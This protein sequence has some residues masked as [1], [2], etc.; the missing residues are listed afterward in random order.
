[1]DATTIDARRSSIDK[2]PIPPPPFDRLPDEIIEQILQATDPNGFASL[3]LLN[4]KWRAASQRSHL[5][6]HHLAKCPSYSTSH[7]TLPSLDDDSLPRLRRLFARE[8]KR[9]LFQAYLRPNQTVIKLISNSISSSSCPGGEGMQFSASPKGHHI[10]AYNSAR[11]YVIDVR[12]SSVELKREFKILR[13]PVAACIND[14]ASLLAV[15]STEMQVDLYD[16][17]QSPPRRTQSMIL[18]NSPRTIALSPCGS[19]LA[20]AYEGGIEVS[21]LRPGALSTDRRAVKCDAVDALAFSYDGTQILGTTTLSAP[22]STVILTAPYYDPGSHMSEENLSALWTTSI[23]FPNTSRDCSHA[24]LLQDGSQEEA[25]WA[26]TYDR[27]FETFR[28]VRIDDLRNGTTYF[29][30]PVPDADSQAKLLPCTL[31]A[32]TY[33]GELV[34]AGFQG[35]DI[36]V[37]GIP[38]DLDA[39]PDSS[40]SSNESGSSGLG[41]QNSA[42]S[43]SSRRMSTRAAQDADGGRV[44]QWQILCDKLRNT[45]ISGCKIAELTEVSNVKWVAGFGQSSTQERLVVTA[46]GVGPARLVTE[47][48]DMDFVDGGR[49]TLVDF[50]YGLDDGNKTEITIEVGTDNAE[51]LEEEQRDLATEV[52]IVRR[53]TVAQ[54]R[55]GR[56]GRS[57]AGGNAMLRTA[58]TAAARAPPVPSQS[59]DEDAADDPLVP[60]MLNRNPVSQPSDPSNGD[61]EGEEATMEEMEALDAPYAHASPRSGTTLRRAATAAAV[62]RT[63]HPRTADGRRI[64]YRRADGRRE[65][66]HESDADNW[67]PPPPPYQKDDPGDLPAFLRGPSV[68]PHTSHLPPPPLPNANAFRSSN[69]QTSNS[70]PQ[71]PAFQRTASDSTTMSRPRAPSSPRPTSSPSVQQDTD[72]LYDITPPES[73]R[74]PARQ[75]TESRPAEHERRHPSNSTVSPIA[76]RA[77]TVPIGSNSR[78]LPLVTMSHASIPSN[79]GVY[80]NAPGSN[81]QTSQSMETHSLPNQ[82]TAPRPRRLSNNQTWPTAPGPGTHQAT[83]LG[84]GY[85]HSVLPVQPADNIGSGL[86]PPPSISQLA[87]LNKRI[88]Q[89]SPRRLSGGF[90]VQRRPVGS[91]HSEMSFARVH[92][93]P[94]S[95]ET[96]R[97]AP[98]EFDQPL[99]ISTPRGVSGAYDPPSRQ[100]SGRRGETPLLAPIPRH[101]RPVPGS[102]NRPTVERL[103]TIYSAT[104]SH[105]PD[106]PPSAVPIPVSQSIPAWLNAPAVPVTRPSP[107]INRRPSRAERSAAK[108]IQDAKKRGWKAKTKKRKK[109]T[110]GASSA[111]WTDVSTTS[112]KQNKEKDKKCIVM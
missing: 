32:A 98:V 82:E 23:L 67:V 43:S 28:S 56:G 27:S 111:G 78:V 71:R 14:I 91:S 99:I 21:S 63:L 35:K 54:K 89:G 34:S 69:A 65:H 104:S 58:T 75:L 57:G 50:D 11:V 112:A 96:P 85:P 88:S 2:T 46:R 90:Q 76:P 36:W 45:V 22:P 15:L 8:V 55:G 52:A 93:D 39:V 12:G 64:E 97:R 108:N 4:R 16:L 61:E 109:N 80:A 83:G 92:T 110:D 105:G 84:L 74:H 48:E 87:S 86:P 107:G 33:H 24:V 44:P 59:R 62:D 73:P 101:P 19:V 13:R 7:T 26:F 42:Q 79:D 30:G 106:I 66:P 94:V 6:I 68:A 37:Y 103:E 1:M 25:S 17:Q 95:P 49:I 47:E 70:S 31:P 53:R 29:T 41:R 38:E 40:S 102:M 81:L 18:D 10:L 3:I 5:Y 72:N 60:R 100:I 20:A 77:V 51:V 9:N